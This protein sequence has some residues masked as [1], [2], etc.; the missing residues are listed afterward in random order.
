MVRRTMNWTFVD[1]TLLCVHGLSPPDP[2][3][4]A[5]FIAES[6]S[7]STKMRQVLV[8]ADVGLSP[9]QRKEVADSVAKAGTKAVAVVC[10]SRLTRTV[11]TGLGWMTRI[12]RA[13]AP[14]AL[15]DAF[16]FL[17]LT[18]KQRAEL[19]RVAKEFA[20]ELNHGELLAI[21]D[22][23]REYRAQG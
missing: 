7:G 3:E 10:F 18:Q 19:L 13:F 1:D 14:A 20:R 12:H 2:K 15:T 23:G 11:V 17:Q 16:D 22:E 5:A 4:W 8:F 9:V 21:L 6:L